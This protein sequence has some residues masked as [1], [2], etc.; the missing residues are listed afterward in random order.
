MCPVADGTHPQGNSAICPIGDWPHSPTIR[1][2]RNT[3][4]FDTVNAALDSL[5]REQII[6]DSIAIDASIDTTADTTGAIMMAIGKSMQLLSIA[7]LFH[8]LASLGK[9]CSSAFI[10]PSG[11]RA[12]LGVIKGGKARKYSLRTIIA[13]FV[14]HIPLM[15]DA[16]NDCAYSVFLYRASRD[17]AAALEH[18]TREMALQNGMV[19]L[20]GLFQKMVIPISIKGLKLIIQTCYDVYLGLRKRSL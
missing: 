9:A 10:S 6:D 2:R 14:Q 1:G 8:S 20:T 19:Q 7:F 4:L 11:G 18:H 15:T 17:M 16:A 5:H 12:I 13:W 3:G